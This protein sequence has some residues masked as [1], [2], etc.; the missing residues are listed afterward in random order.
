M[1]L[2]AKLSIF[3]DKKCAFP[4]PTK[5]VVSTPLPP[6]NGHLSTTATFL[7]SQGGLCGAGR[8]DF[9]PYCPRGICR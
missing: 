7:C 1:Y 2:H 6:H 5:G 9:N 8:L 4:T 3:K